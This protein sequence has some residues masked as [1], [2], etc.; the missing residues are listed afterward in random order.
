MIFRCETILAGAFVLAAGSILAPRARADEPAR[1]QVGQVV[2]EDV[3]EVPAALTE[4][5]QQYLNVR[6]ASLLDFDDAGERIL[7]GTR[8]GNTEQL[9]IVDHPGGDRRQIT[10]FDEPI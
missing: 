3:P 10:F 7:I 5:M 2:L 6:A 8:F 1:R 4:R 9:H